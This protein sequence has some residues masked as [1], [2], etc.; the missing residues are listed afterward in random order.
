MN[1]TR[2][3]YRPDQWTGTLSYIIQ[4]NRRKFLACMM[5]GILSNGFISAA[6]PLALKYLF[7]EGIIRRDFTRFVV[8]SFLFVTVF[9]LWRVGVYFYR[10]YAQTLK[11][12]VFAKLSLR[13]LDKYY[14]L[15]YAEVTKRDHGYFLSRIYDE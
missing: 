10:Q 6:N 5:L 1:D 13:M 3:K 4:G 9:T 7:D 8:V 12:A 14:E 11:N 2:E 15:P